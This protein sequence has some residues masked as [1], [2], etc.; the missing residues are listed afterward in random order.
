MGGSGSRIDG[1]RVIARVA[2]YGKR[3]VVEVDGRAPATLTRAEARRPRSRARE[4]GGEGLVANMHGQVV[5]V[6]AKPGDIVERG[7]TLVVIEAMKMR[8][9]SRRRT[10]GA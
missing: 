4:K 10:E 1:R 3:R 2:D 5:A 7:A 6:P 8:S 9:A